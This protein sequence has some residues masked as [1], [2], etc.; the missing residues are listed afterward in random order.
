MHAGSKAV[1][2]RRRSLPHSILESDCGPVCLRA[3]QIRTSD[4]ARKLLHPDEHLV[5]RIVGFPGLHVV[6]NGR[7]SFAAR[8]VDISGGGHVGKVFVHEGNDAGAALLEHVH[9]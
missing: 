3:C 5:T 7:A 1:L 4:A 6:G 2:P 9:P 8:N